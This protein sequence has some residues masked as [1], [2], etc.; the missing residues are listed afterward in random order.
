MTQTVLSAMGLNP[1]PDGIAAAQRAEGVF[2]DL[3]E[4]RR[5]LLLLYLKGLLELQYTGVEP[6][7]AGLRAMRSCLGTAPSIFERRLPD[8]LAAML[9]REL[10]D[11]ESYRAF[12]AG[13]LAESLARGDRL[14]AWKAGWGLGQT[15]FLQQRLDAAITVMDEAIA[16][17]RA[18]QRLRA[19]ALMVGQ[20]AL[21]RLARDASETTLARVREAVDLLRSDEQ[22]AY[23]LGNA[24]PWLAWWQGRAGDALRL[25]C[26][27]D[28]A[29]VQHG[30][31]RGLV[32]DQLRAA[33]MA[34]IA[35]PALPAQSGLDEE[36]AL[37][38]A[39]ASP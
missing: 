28:E 21:M 32:S 14:E 33:F 34:S 36:G 25:Q 10:G 17:M 13:M 38:L 30:Y 24:L 35:G 11:L 15:L 4:R 6:A 31:K 20:G 8:W 5:L 3:G 19:N 27:A 2:R 7:Q 16:D 23:S 18:S 37:R 9:A 22:V 26:W 29:A 1:A 39:L 12:W